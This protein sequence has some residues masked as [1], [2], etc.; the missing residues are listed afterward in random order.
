MNW[1]RRI[2]IAVLMSFALVTMAQ[3][4]TMPNVDEHLQALSTKLDL[5]ADQ[6]AKIRPILKE[7][8]DG[9]QKID[10]DQSLSDAARHEKKEAVFM[11]ADKQARRYLSAEQKKKL[12]V[13]ENE[14]HSGAH[15][16]AH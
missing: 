1:I 16:S 2:A 14:V 5:T 4:A 8:Q 6:Q 7:M 10:Q 9:M 12:D 11:N 15:D 13:M 3:E